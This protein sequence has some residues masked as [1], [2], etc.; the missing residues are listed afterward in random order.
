MKFQKDENQIEKQL[1][2]LKFGAFLLQEALLKLA[3]NE[4][5]YVQ[6]EFPEYDLGGSHYVQPSIK[7]I[8]DEFKFILPKSLFPLI[9]KFTLNIKEKKKEII[10]K[11]ELLTS[12]ITLYHTTT[13]QIITLLEERLESYSNYKE[14]E[15]LSFRILPYEEEEEENIKFFLPDQTVLH[16]DIKINYEELI[17]SWKKEN[18]FQGWYCSNTNSEDCIHVDSRNRKIFFWRITNILTK[19]IILLWFSNLEME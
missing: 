12:D 8:Q 9:S 1:V 3:R 18:S 6:D 15:D 16:L 14:I 11:I 10:K 7:L 5:Y 19:E 2:K 17:Q 13:E 4:G